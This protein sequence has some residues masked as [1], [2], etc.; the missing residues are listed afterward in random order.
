VAAARAEE[1]LLG[2]LEGE[3]RTLRGMNAHQVLGIGYEAGEAEARAAFAQL[4]KRYHPD[5]F[6]RF[7]SPRARQ[8]A[9]DLFVLLREAYRRVAEASGRT[10]AGPAHPTPMR[11]VPILDTAVPIVVDDLPGGAPLRRPGTPAQGVPAQVPPRRLG[12]PAHGVPLAAPGPPPGPAAASAVRPRRATPA[13][14]GSNLRPPESG[15]PGPAPARSVVPFKPPGPAPAAPAAPAAPQPAG[16]SRLDADFLFGDLGAAPAARVAEPIGLE[17][18][19]G[20]EAEVLVA[21]GRIVEAGALFD[22]TSTEEPTHRGARA[23]RELGLGMKKLAD[24]EREA[25]V[26]HLETALELEPWSDRAARELAALRRAATERGKGLLSKLLGKGE[27]R[28]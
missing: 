6:A 8:I 7:Q 18:P 20:V 14:G 23:G 2:A 4:S 16:G 21:A 5:R 10:L 26:R 3:L 12:T 28:E 24:G 11:G 19:R 25:A 13:H 9:A 1:D 15:A 17:A 22:Q 27:G